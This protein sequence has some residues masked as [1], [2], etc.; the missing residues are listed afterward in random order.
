MKRFGIT[1]ALFTLSIPLTWI[2]FLAV[3]S[4]FPFAY[5]MLVGKEKRIGATKERIEEWASNAELRASVDVLFF[6]SSTCYLAI[7]PAALAPHRLSGF[8]FCT[9]AQTIGH[10]ASF[11]SAALSE[12]H[13][14]L[15]VVDAY[16]GLWESGAYGAESI[17]DWAVNAK[18]VNGVWE[19]A[20]MANAWKAGDPYSL[21]LTV[22][23]NLNERLRWYERGEEETHSEYRGRGFVARSY[24]PLVEAPVCPPDSFRTFSAA[25]CAALGLMREL[26]AEHGAE[27]VLLNPPQLCPETFDVPAC[28]EGLHV[29]DGMDWPERNRPDHYY[30]DHHLVAAGAE[31]Y[32]VWVAEQVAN[33]VGR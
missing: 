21:L 20:R 17:R 29:I 10:A 2:L 13:P 3:A 15:V 33:R 6:G 25:H 9:S 12:S 28:W 32:S 26:C 7:D 11:L 1:L 31:R 5:D 16:P 18:A 14:R 22:W 23:K 27:L 24:A 19:R 30:D 4:K 8:N